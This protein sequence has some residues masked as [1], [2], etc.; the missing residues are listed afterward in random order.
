MLLAVQ[1]RCSDAYSIVIVDMANP[2]HEDEADGGSDNKGIDIEKEKHHVFLLH[3]GEARVIH[4]EETWKSL[5]YSM[6]NKT[7]E[8]SLV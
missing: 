3:K 4:H 8:V 5:G 1:W 6:D 7:C 2:E